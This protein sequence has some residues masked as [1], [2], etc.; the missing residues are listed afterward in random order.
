M[1]PPA[2]T[3]KSSGA[4]S[5]GKWVA[6]TVSGKI[7][8]PFGMRFH[9]VLK[10]NKM[11]SGIDL[12][13]PMGTPIAAV[14]DGEVIFAGPAKGYGNL[15][16]IRHSNGLITRYGHMS[17]VHVSEGQKIPAGFRIG[18]SGSEGLSTAPHLHFETIMNGKH[19]DPTTIFSF[20]GAP[21]KRKG[22]TPPKPAAKGKPKEVQGP[23]ERK[24]GYHF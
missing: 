21:A 16:A 20:G 2:T 4:A 1:T 17:K 14:G 8:S 3:P 7:T 24:V 23:P 5:G 15:V 9:P 12:R 10:R 6:P 22:A 11:H 18:D 13:A 19:V